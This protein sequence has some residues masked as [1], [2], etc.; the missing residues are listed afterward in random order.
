MKVFAVVH[1]MGMIIVMINAFVSED[2]IAWLICGTPIIAVWAWVYSNYF[3]SEEM[4]KN[5]E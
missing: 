5:I 4:K 3:K 1:V 2:N